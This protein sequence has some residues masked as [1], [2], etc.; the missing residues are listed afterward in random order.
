MAAQVRM[1]QVADGQAKLEKSLIELR[2]NM[3]ILR[4]R[5]EIA[6]VPDAPVPQNPNVRNEIEIP[7]SSLV[8]FLR[9]ASAMVEEVNATVLDVSKRLEL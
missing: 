7:M 2:E 5:L 4:G 6:C 9:H 8:A 3:M 1:P